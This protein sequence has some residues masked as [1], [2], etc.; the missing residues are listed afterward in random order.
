MCSVVCSV[1]CGVM[2]GVMCS[3]MCSVMQRNASQR[4]ATGHI[5]RFFPKQAKQAPSS[6]VECHN[7]NTSATNSHALKPANRI[8]IS[9]GLNSE[10]CDFLYDPGSEYS[11]ITRAAY[12]SK[13]FQELMRILGI[14]KI[15]TS[16][17]RPQTNGLTEQSNSSI[18]KF[19]RVFR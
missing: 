14:K 10:K 2:C 1:M 7:V 6:G 12:E 5:S 9:F 4:N 11:M 8:M 13:L 19:N 17:Y 18:K 15:R 16:G 3:V